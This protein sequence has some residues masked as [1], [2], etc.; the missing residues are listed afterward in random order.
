VTCVTD[1]AARGSSVV[2]VAGCCT[3][4]VNIGDIKCAARAVEDLS[5]SRLVIVFR[6]DQLRADDHEV[7]VWAIVPQLTSSGIYR[8]VPG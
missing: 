5:P 2:F 6:F 3:F 1:F 4:P 8:V 7:A